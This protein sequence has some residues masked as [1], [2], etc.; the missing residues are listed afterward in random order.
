MK[1]T[2]INKDDGVLILKYEATDNIEHLILDTCS[3]GVADTNVS[4]GRDYFRPEQSVTFGSFKIPVH[5]LLQAKKNENESNKA[6]A[7]P[8]SEP[9]LPPPDPRDNLQL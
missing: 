4:L 2:V 7:T 5:S 8:A 9:Q 1:V 6:Q 3:M